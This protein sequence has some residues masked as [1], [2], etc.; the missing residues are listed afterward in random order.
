VCVCVCVCS[1]GFFLFVCL[2]CFYSSYYVALSIHCVDHA[3][4]ELT[5]ICLPL[6][7]VLGLKA[8][9]TKPVAVLV[10]FLKIN[11]PTTFTLSCTL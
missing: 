9:S 4:L 1:L 6:P 5:E 3:D 11:Y 8:C 2:F 7:L 10:R